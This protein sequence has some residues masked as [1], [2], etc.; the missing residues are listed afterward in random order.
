MFPLSAVLFPYGSMSLHVFE[1][2]YRAL[3]RDC[4]AGDRRFGVV[5]IERGSEVGGGDQ[6]AMLG[7]RSVIVRAGELP[8]GRWL[9]AVLGE[10][11]LEVD[12]WLPDDPYPRA[13]VHE[14]QVPPGRPPEVGELL[15]T[16]TGRVRHA[17]A[18]LAE[19]GGAPPLAPDASL[20][21]GG[22]ATVAAWQLCGAAPLSAYDAQ[23]LLAA[24]D[25]AERLRLLTV[26]VEELELDLRRMLAAE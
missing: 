14:R 6:R 25:V 4:L 10:A 26:I 22:D 19:H 17:R 3:V 8:D 2:R 16:A 1:A 12:E 11:V 5:L 24:A 23:R 15:A 13:R 9:L 20:D 18:L 7:T 21:G